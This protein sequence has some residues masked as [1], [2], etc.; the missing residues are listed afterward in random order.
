M[1][2][3][4]YDKEG[5]G[6]ARPRGGEGGGGKGSLV[7]AMHRGRSSVLQRLLV[8]GRVGQELRSQ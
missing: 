1:R 8:A 2:R 5:G 7:V 4:M 6:Q 3:C